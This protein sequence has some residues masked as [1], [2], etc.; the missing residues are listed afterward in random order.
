MELVTVR[1]LAWSHRDPSYLG[2]VMGNLVLRVGSLFLFLS[3]CMH[4]PLIS[5]AWNR[6]GKRYVSLGGLAWDSSVHHHLGI[7]L[8]RRVFCLVIL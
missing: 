6:L 5:L 8:E 2:C 3:T 7:G 4:T 1:H